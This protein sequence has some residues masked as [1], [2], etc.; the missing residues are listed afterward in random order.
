MSSVSALSAMGAAVF[1]PTQTEAACVTTGLTTSCD[2]ATPNPWT[3]TVGNGGTA[4]DNRIVIVESGAQIKVSEDNA[5]SLGSNVQITIKSGATV[6]GTVNTGTSGRNGMGSNTIDFLSNGMLTI[7]EGAVVEALGT[8]GSAEAINVKTGGNTIINSGRIHGAN[9]SAIFFEN[10]TGNQRNTIINNNETGVISTGV[11]GGNVIGSMGNSATDFTNKGRI[12]GNL[13]FAGGDDILHLFAGSVITGSM[14]GGGGTD[15]IFLEGDGDDTLAGNLDGF[16]EF[17]KRG[18]GTWTLSGTIAGLTKVDIREGKLVLT[19][20]NSNAT[21][22]IT[23]DPGA[24][25]A[26]RA[27]SLPSQVHNDNG[28]VEFLQTDDGTYG[29]VISGGGQIIKEEAGTLTLTGTNTYSGGTLVKKGLINI[30]SDANLGDMKGGVTL[31]GGGLQFGTGF[32]MKRNV[33]LAAGG[34]TVDTMANASS[35]DSPITGAGGLTKIGSGVLT[36]SGANGYKGGTEV[37]GGHLVIDG[38]QSAATGLVSVGSGATLSGKGVTGGDVAIGDGGRLQV[39]S[40]AGGAR[41]LTIRG[42]L[43]LGQSATID[44]SYGQTA[45]GVPA[46][47]LAVNV[48]GDLT[49]DGTINVSNSSGAA[50]PIPGLYRLI[51]YAGTLTDNG[52]ALG[53]LPEGDFFLQTSVDHQVNLVSYVGASANFWDGSG[54]RNDGRIEGGDGVWQA[55]GGNDNWTEKTGRFNVPYTDNNFAIFTGKAGTVTVDNS[56]GNVRAEGMQFAVDGYVVRGGDIELGEDPAM[57]RVG[58]GTRAGADYQATI[59]SRL[60]GTAKLVKNDL[61]RLVLTGSNSYSGGT[62]VEG[63]VLQLGDGGTSGSIAGA[64]A[65]AGGTSLVANRSDSLTLAGAISGDGKVV[66]AGTGTTMLRGANSYKGGTEINAGTLNVAS[67]ASLGDAASRVTMN[68]GRLQAGASFE[69]AHGVTLAAADNIIDTQAFNTTLAGSIDGAGAL[70]KTGTG[71]LTLTGAASYAG[72]SIVSQGTLALAGNGDIAASAGVTADAGFDI[73]GITAD[74]TAIKGLSGGR[75]GRVHLGDKG[76]VITAAQED[77]FAGVIDGAGGLAVTGGRQVLSGDNT[78]AGG[79]TVGPKGALQI[80]DGGNTGSVK[81]GIAIDGLLA[82]NRSDIFTADNLLTGPGTL[83]Q[84]GRGTTLLT[85]D[86][87]GFTGTTNIHAGALQV[88]H[89]LGGTMNVLAGGM[90]QGEGMVG[91]TANAGT[92]AP[93]NGG[94]DLGTL[95]I[96]GDYAGNGGLIRLNTVLGDDTS[97][98]DLL[99]ITGN[100]SGASKVRVLNRGGLGAQT[101][102]GIKIIDVGGQSDGTFTLIG[103]YTTKDGKSA[104]VGGAYAYTLNKNGL[105]SPTSRDGDWYLRSE[106]IFQPGAPLY[107][108]YGQVLN[109]LNTLPTLAQRTGNRYWAGTGHMPIPQGDG[110]GIPDEAVPYPPESGPAQA[111]LETG[112]LIWNRIEAA[113]AHHRPDTSTTGAEYDIDLW[114]GQIG[115]DGQFHEDESGRLIGSIW[116]SYGNASADIEAFYGDGKI[117]TSGYGL[118]GALTWYDD[119]GYYLDGQAQVTWFDSDL[120]SSTLGRTLLDGDK[121]IGYAL[122]SETG[123]RYSLT[124]SWTLTPQAQITYAQAMLDDFTDPYGA[125]VNYRHNARLTGRIGVAA[126]YQTAWQDQDGY[127][128]RADLY[129][130]LNL[131]QAFLDEVRMKFERHTIESTEEK[132]WAE[133]GAGG[134]YNWND[135][136]YVLFGAISAQT[137]LAHPGESYK[138]TGNAGFKVKW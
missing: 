67:A 45:G 113:H 40:D 117:E 128:R 44:Y 41:A 59:A 80:G 46:N 56:K 75:D 55:R 20:N 11:A 114:K 57:I 10:E 96:N 16:E 102:D 5:I 48:G 127:G 2:T 26:A 110:P 68:G 106:Y 58:D 13:L 35:I 14:N 17:T 91:S 119:S 83:E 124:D 134:T 121:A 97:Q 135:D 122:S 27:Q 49:L 93:G 12:E 50:F 123:L 78:Y 118:G 104:V 33:T 60:T 25:L 29:G 76:L 125:R 85:A 54:G 105:A 39:S 70:H 89:R 22:I 30:S 61:G 8:E 28:T 19:G 73:S 129:G 38:N 95:T 133:I 87:A 86:N 69:T 103:D 99:V 3:T 15:Q 77:D 84:I 94:K 131:H 51:N 64:I 24:T 116:V 52:A 62:S 32:A 9:T 63:G 92:I 4:E 53:T 36:L 72:R 100:T 23:V 109:H 120:N 47:V 130:I 112:V 132:T 82:F 101:E 98:T 107:E 136:R 1:L 18:T 42:D 108:V 79:T 31:D 7:E 34:G 90:L 43:S 6:S 138:F 65:L 21:G 115:I 111:F 137:G 81:G 71:R 126:N 88:D 66:Q 37:Q 74:T